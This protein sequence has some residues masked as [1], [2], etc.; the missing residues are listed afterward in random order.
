MPLEKLTL[1]RL[2][3]ICE[4]LGGTAS[5]CVVTGVAASAEEAAFGGVTGGDCE[6][7]GAERMR[8]VAAANL[9]FVGTRMLVRRVFSK[10][11][12]ARRGLETRSPWNSSP[13]TFAFSG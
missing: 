7:R 13:R 9:I 10:E 8:L 12:M 4:G 6:Y 5:C 1:A 11:V 2:G 3:G